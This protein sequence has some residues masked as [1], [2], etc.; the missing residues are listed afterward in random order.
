MRKPAKATLSSIEKNQYLALINV[1][2][3]LLSK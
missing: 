1:S 3:E 2:L